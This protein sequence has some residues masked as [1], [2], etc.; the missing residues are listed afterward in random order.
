MI[1]HN[2]GLMIMKGAAK[3]IVNDTY[4]QCITHFRLDILKWYG[5]KVFVKLM[6]VL[7]SKQVLLLTLNSFFMPGAML[8][9]VVRMV[10]PVHLAV[11]ALMAEMVLYVFN[12]K[13]FF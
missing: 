3:I 7:I 10:R 4:A 6:I 13:C 11:M 12:D 9:L 5:Y 1:I 2:M 8:V